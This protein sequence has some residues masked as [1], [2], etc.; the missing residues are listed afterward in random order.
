[1]KR[2]LLDNDWP[3][4]YQRLWHFDE[5]E[6]WNQTLEPTGNRAYHRRIE[7]CLDWIE[8][9]TPPADVLDIGSAQANLALLLAERG[10]RVTANDINPESLEYARLKYETGN[11][12]WA[13]GNVFKLDLGKQFDAVILGEVIEHVAHPDEMV[14][15]CRGY[16]RVGGYLLVTTP[17]GEYLRN[18]LPTFYSAPKPEEMERRQFM[19]DADGH[20]FA[21]TRHELRELI[22]SSGFKV[23]DHKVSHTPFLTERVRRLASRI[24]LSPALL[25]IFDRFIAA[26]PLLGTKLCM[27]QAVLGQLES[28]SKAET[29]K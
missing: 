18:R 25:E 21:F 12:E 10:Y 13:S 7:L 14:T 5:R 26:I 9:L 29:A 15:M 22:V 11:I 23:V 16:L 28:S 2:L 24:L 20:L 4:E 1:M 6:F 17:N 3:Q 8:R 27:E 19:P